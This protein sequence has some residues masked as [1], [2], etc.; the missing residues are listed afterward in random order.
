MRRQATT[1]S[2]SRPRISSWWTYQN[3]IPRK[4]DVEHERHLE[5]DGDRD[6]IPMFGF[7]GKWRICRNWQDC[8]TWWYAQPTASHS[9]E[10]VGYNK[11]DGLG[12]TQQ[13]RRKNPLEHYLK[14]VSDRSGDCLVFSRRQKVSTSLTQSS[15]CSG[16]WELPSSLARI[17]ANRIAWNRVGVR[18]RVSRTGSTK[19]QED[20]LESL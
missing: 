12:T 6:V 14:A 15:K 9:S 13:C 20:G 19:S 8:Y 11:L 7:G 17:S 4:S 18:E 16:T 2:R 1:C 5:K 10:A 3:G